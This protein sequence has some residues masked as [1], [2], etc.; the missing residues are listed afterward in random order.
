MEC[1]QTEF[2]ETVEAFSKTILTLVKYFYNPQ[3]LFELY[4]Q[5]V[6]QTNTLFFFQINE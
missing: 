2:I 4:K 3:K 6:I 1:N 5:L